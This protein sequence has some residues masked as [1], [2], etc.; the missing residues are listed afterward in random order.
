MRHIT[1]LHARIAPN[2][3]IGAV[4]QP[5]PLGQVFRPSRGLIAVIAN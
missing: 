1:G 4:W 5:D 2:P 3:N